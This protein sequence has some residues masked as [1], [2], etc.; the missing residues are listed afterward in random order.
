MEN[1]LE[2]ARKFF[3]DEIDK[4][5]GEP[6]IP[7]DHPANLAKYAKDELTNEKI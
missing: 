3:N 7:F 2:N 1:T 6:S 5:M 4:W